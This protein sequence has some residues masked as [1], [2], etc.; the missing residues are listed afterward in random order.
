M[1]AIG[2]RATAP[3]PSRSKGAQRK[4]RLARGLRRWDLDRQLCAEPT[5]RIA[6]LTLTIPEKDP[7]AAIGRVYQF[8][9]R[10]RRRWLGT[11]YFCWLEL[12]RRGAVHYQCVWLN[13]PHVKQVNLLAWVDR[14]WGGGRTQVRFSDGRRGLEREIEY[15]LGYAKKMGRKAY[16]QRYDEVPRELRTFMSQRLEIP[17]PEI[18]RHLEG[19]VWEYRAEQ[20][21]RADPAEP[22]ANPTPGRRILHYL[23]PAHLVL[24]GH[25]THDIPPGG[26]CTALDHRRQRYKKKPPQLGA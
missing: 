17:P 18:D 21:L 12:Q 5:R 23:E 15:A 1:R 2:D 25:R 24:V 7:E 8:W 22:A 20:L 10:V 19:D 4:R 6:T 13:P 16:Q 3:I 14:A 11:R 26:R 9:G